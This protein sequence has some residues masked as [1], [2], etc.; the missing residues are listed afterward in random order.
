VL[1]EV[2]RVHAHLAGAE[3]GARVRT[4]QLALDPARRLVRALLLDELARYRRARRYPQNH[5]FRGHVAP[6]FIDAHGTRCAVAH[7]LEIGGEGELVQEIAKKRNFARVRELANERRLL[8]FLEAAGLTV[9]EAARIQ[10][11]YCFKTPAYEC[12]CRDFHPTAVMEG[13]VVAPIGR[14]HA[15]VH[16][17][18]IHGN[19]G[20]FSEGEELSAYNHAGAE[21]GTPVLLMPTAPA[22]GAAPELVAEWNVA[23]GSVTV[24]CA[25]QSDTSSHPLPT[26][27]AIDA[28]LA[29]DEAQCEA[30]LGSYDDYWA[31]EPCDD[32]GCGCRML[33]NGSAAPSSATL[34]ILAALLTYRRVRALRLRTGR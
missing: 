32:S 17:E 23:G 4:P 34:A 5:D 25:Y 30:K 7:L 11:S 12:F 29:K 14:E 8:A 1:V 10:P 18:R 20:P 26:S 28:L 24:R 33:P 19:P 31:K 2:A 22:D 15:T 27:V 9:E 16:L 13:T 21:P 6:V 3:S